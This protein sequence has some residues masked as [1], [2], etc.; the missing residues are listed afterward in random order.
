[1]DAGCP[2]QSLPAEDNTV[3]FQATSNSK[4][5]GKNKAL[6]PIIPSNTG[7]SPTWGPK[8]S[9]KGD[10]DQFA[11]LPRKEKSKKSASRETDNNKESIENGQISP[12]TSDN[13]RSKIVTDNEQAKPEP[14]DSENSRDTNDTQESGHRRGS[15]KVKKKSSEQAV[16]AVANFPWDKNMQYVSDHKFTVYDSLPPRKHAKIE[17][18]KQ[19]RGESQ[20]ENA[21]NS[22]QIFGDVEYKRKVMASDIQ[23]ALIS[24]K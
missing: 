18:M 2:I 17:H 13:D 21:A 4:I 1:M 7:Y 5:E 10:Y 3:N 24:H 8:I 23:G 15:V 6:S 9:V 19:V 12:P 11:R 16:I 20:Y 14:R 22:P